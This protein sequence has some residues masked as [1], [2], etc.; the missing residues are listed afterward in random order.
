MGEGDQGHRR[1]DQLTMQAA[2]TAP[3]TATCMLVLS[4]I[5]QFSPALAQTSQQDQLLTATSSA[6]TRSAACSSSIAKAYNLCTI[7]GFFNITSVKCDCT[8][9]DVPGAPMWECVGTAVCK[10]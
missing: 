7:R 2:F 3:G 4:G 8:Q 6:P 5:W 9:A 1:D 10:K